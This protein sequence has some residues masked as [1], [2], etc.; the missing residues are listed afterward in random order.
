MREPAHNQL[1]TRE[2]QRRLTITCA[3]CKR[4]VEFWEHTANRKLGIIKFR[5]FCHGTWSPD[6]IVSIEMLKH[7]EI[8][9]AVA[10]VE[11]IEGGASSAS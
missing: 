9:S 3:K 2:L 5:A 6:T 8:V 1:S 4:P 7:D 11:L 10:F